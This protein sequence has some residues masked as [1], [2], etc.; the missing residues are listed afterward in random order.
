MFIS[1]T[2]DTSKLSG[3]NRILGRVL[4]NQIDALSTIDTNVANNAARI[5]RKRYG[6]KYTI[7]LLYIE[8][9]DFSTYNLSKH[10]QIK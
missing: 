4:K 5:K 3:V 6:F 2:D 10:T 8:K 7:I 9:E 1:G